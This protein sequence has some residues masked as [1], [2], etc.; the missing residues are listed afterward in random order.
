MSVKVT[1]KVGRPS[2]FEKALEFWGVEVA[3][4]MKEAQ[5]AIGAVAS[6]ASL[7]AYEVVISKKN[8]IDLLTADYI[9]FLIE[10][11]GPGGFPPP[12]NIEQWIR[13]KGIVPEGITIKQLAYLIGRKIA[14]LGTD[15][16]EGRA[17]GI[18]LDAILAQAYDNISQPYALEVAE[19]AG[20]DLTNSMLTYLKNF[21]LKASK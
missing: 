17:P 4:M 8:N 7:E 14:Q 9:L 21:D 10:G 19:Q 18:P 13:E 16:Y 6:G 15:I 1:R 11:R 3:E 20:E 12:G 2:H 5:I